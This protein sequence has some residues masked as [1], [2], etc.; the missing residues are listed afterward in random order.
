[1]PK[2]AA[3]SAPCVPF[4]AP[5]GAI[6]STRILSSSPPYHRAR[7]NGQY[8]RPE[9]P[10]YVRINKIF[11]RNGWWCFGPS[12]HYFRVHAEDCVDQAGEAGVEVGLAQA[13]EALGA[14]DPLGDDPGL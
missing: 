9:V 13:H 12:G 5:G 10:P 7:R 4:P 6:I 14:L 1:M 8:L 11:F 2:C 3:I